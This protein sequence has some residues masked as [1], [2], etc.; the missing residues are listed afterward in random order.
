MSAP[1]AEKTNLDT[2]DFS[3][4]FEWSYRYYAT[5]FTA[6]NEMVTREVLLPFIVES[7][8]QF[9]TAAD[10]ITEHYMGMGLR[11]GK[12]QKLS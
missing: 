6:D 7:R 12:L 2:I 10:L 5:C 3:A 1:V 8:L 11:V 9:A 4:G